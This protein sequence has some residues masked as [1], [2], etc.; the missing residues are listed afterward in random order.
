[1]LDYIICHEL[2]HLK[3]PDHG[4]SFRT[5]IGNQIP[6]WRKRHRNLMCSVK[7]RLAPGGNEIK[8]EQPLGGKQ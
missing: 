1:L 4:K 3:I 7:D 6:D 8:I 2:I 5:L